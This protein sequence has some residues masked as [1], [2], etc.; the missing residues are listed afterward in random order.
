MPVPYPISTLSPMMS[1]P[2]SVQASS[3][4][5]AGMTPTEMQDVTG[6]VAELESL[7]VISL[8]VDRVRQVGRGGGDQLPSVEQLCGRC[9]DGTLAVTPGGDVLPCVFARWLVLGNVRETALRSI[10]QSAALTRRELRSRFALRAGCDPRCDPDCAPR[11]QP[12]PPGGDGQV[13]GCPPFDP[14]R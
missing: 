8:S 6:A 12:C 7:G 1:K 10:N 5:P 3:A 11:C 13:P 14:R 9:A 4:A 2:V